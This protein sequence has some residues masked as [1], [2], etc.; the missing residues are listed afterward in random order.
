LEKQ[1]IHITIRDREHVDLFS[2]DVC[3]LGFTSE[4]IVERSIAWFNDPSP[5]YRHRAAV[6][7]RIIIELVDFLSRKSALGVHQLLLNQL[8][9]DLRNAFAYYRHA[10]YILF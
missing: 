7:Q 1:L 4:H 9:H 3:G 10:A 6:E 2:G 5:C 8:P